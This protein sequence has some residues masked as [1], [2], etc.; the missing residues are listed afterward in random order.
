VSTST[1]PLHSQPSDLH[2]MAEIRFH[3]RI[4][5]DQ[6]RRATSPRPASPQSNRV[7]SISNSNLNPCFVADLVKSIVNKI[8]NQNLQMI[9]CWNPWDV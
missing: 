2:R 3:S 5:I 8:L 9:P 6:W 4:G 1:V 7:K